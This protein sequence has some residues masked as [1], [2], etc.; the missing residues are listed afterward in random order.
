[1]SLFYQNYIIS[2]MVTSEDKPCKPQ[3]PSW[4]Y[5]PMTPSGDKPFLYVPGEN[6]SLHSI[7]QNEAR[8]ICFPDSNN[9]SN[10]PYHEI[11]H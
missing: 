4:L 7:H 8:S 10:N 6:G 3:S 1:M 11:I 9:V 5:L 2:T